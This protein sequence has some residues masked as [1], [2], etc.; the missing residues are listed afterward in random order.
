MAKLNPIA[1]SQRTECELDEAVTVGCHAHSI[2]PL[3]DP[4]LSKEHVR[5]EQQPPAP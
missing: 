4:L 3:L 5:V 2:I 1:G